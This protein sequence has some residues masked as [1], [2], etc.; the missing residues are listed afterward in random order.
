MDIKYKYKLNIILKILK[1]YTNLFLTA[2]MMYF[3]V[4]LDS[5]FKHFSSV[6]FFIVTLHKNTRQIKLHDYLSVNIFKQMYNI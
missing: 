5:G 4:N 6:L 3:C 2:F 1:V